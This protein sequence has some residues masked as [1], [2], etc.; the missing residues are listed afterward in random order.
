MKYYIIFLFVIITS[1]SKA[2]GY[3]FSYLQNSSTAY[4]SVESDSGYTVIGLSANSGSFNYYY[5]HNLTFDGD[6]LDSWNF[7]VDTAWNTQFS[8]TNSISNNYIAGSIGISDGVPLGTLTAF[9]SDFSDTVFSIPFSI[10]ERQT[11]FQN[12]LQVNDSSLLIG[13]WMPDDIEYDYYSSMIKMDTSGSILWERDFYCGENCNLFPRN[14]N[15][16]SDGGYF[17]VADEAHNSFTTDLYMKSVIIKTDEL[18]FEEYRYHPE[19]DSTAVIGGWVVPTL[20]GNYITAYSDLYLIDN[21]SANYDRTL[22][23]EKFDLEGNNLWT[24]DLYDELPLTEWGSGYGYTINSMMRKDSSI[25]IAGETVYEGFLISINDEGEVNWYRYYMP[26]ND[27]DND[28]PYGS[29]W[30]RVKGMTLTS[31]GGILLT[32]SYFSV[33]SNLYPD[34]IAAA[35]AFKVDEY[36]C[37]EPGC[38]LADEVKEISAQKADFEL[39]PNP[40]KDDLRISMRI[41]NEKSFSVSIINV[42]GSALIH[43][44]GL[45]DQDFI[46]IS[47]LATGMYILQIELEDGHRSARK[48]VKE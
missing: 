20:D 32:G 21:Q 14:F 43:Q 40:A 30:L 18:G 12:M 10:D 1:L 46:D 34:G 5:F 19:Q 39:F 11:V 3:F 2:Q 42:N 16:I 35:V 31:D 48:F 7:E 15:I 28:V 33:P 25:L 41:N 17:F 29:D 13:A 6:T 9:T 4:S 37:M 47:K 38:Q 23:I 45:Q 24:I 27:D 44:T 26:P 8:Y 36:G 22:W